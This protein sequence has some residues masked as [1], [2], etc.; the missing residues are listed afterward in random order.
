MSNESVFVET[1]RDDRKG[2]AV[3][4]LGAARELGL[5]SG[6]VRTQRNGYLVPQEVHDEYIDALAE[7]AERVDADGGDDK[8]D[9]DQAKSAREAA[10]AKERELQ[11][12]ADDE[13]AP[14][15]ESDEAKAARE[16][17]EADEEEKLQ[18]VERTITEENV[19]SDQ[20]EPVV[21]TE[22]ATESTELQTPAPKKAPAKKTPAAKKAPAKKSATSAATK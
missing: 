9:A 6:V 8:R 1:D 20:K 5:D 3:L 19:V 10:E 21:S 7:K 11:E 16:K 13:N 17:A 14:Q 4:L 22:A 12:L 2:Q 15:P 18:R